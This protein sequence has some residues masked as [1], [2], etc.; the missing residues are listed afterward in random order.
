VQTSFVDDADD[1]AKEILPA[2]TNIKLYQI[3][4]I[5]DNVDYLITYHKLKEIKVC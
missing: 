1:I 5:D 3:R 4:F 2:L